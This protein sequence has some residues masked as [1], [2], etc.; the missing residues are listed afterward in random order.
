[1]H[2]VDLVVGREGGVDDARL[3]VAVVEHLAHALQV[4]VD[5]HAHELDLQ[6]ELVELLVE[7][8]P[9]RYW[10][11]RSTSWHS[12]EPP[13]DVVLGPLV[14][15]VGEDLLGAVELDQHAGAAVGSGL[16]SV[17]KKAV[18]SDT[19]AACC[20]LW[21]TMTIV[22]SSLISCIRSSMRAV[23]MGSSAEHGSSIRITSGSRGDGPGDAQALLLAAGQAD[24]RRP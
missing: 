8:G 6:P 17:V 10:R 12:A 4:L 2:G 23:A 22:Y 13:G 3:G 5:A 14:G 18:P 11:R 15:G 19:R 1:M 9:Q 20:M 7:D 24:G 21:V 16:T